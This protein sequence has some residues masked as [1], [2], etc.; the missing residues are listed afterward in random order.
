MKQN[1]CLKTFTL[2][3]AITLGATIASA[4]SADVA[5]PVPTETAT[6]GLLG[7]RYTEVAYNY[8]DLSGPEHADGFGLAFNQPLRANLDL[9]AGYNW[10]EADFGAVSARVHDAEIGVKAYT[11]LS[12]G[13]PYAAAAVGWTW[14]KAAG[15]SEDSF[16]Y[17]VG[18]GAE[19]QVAPAFTV[20]PFVNFVRATGFNASEVEIGARATYRLNSEWSLTARAQHEVVRHDDNSQEYSIGAIYRF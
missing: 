2:A 14:Q 10:A 19:F 1:T 8:I 6:A 20:T 5:V 17:K 9:T 15:Y 7:S 12:W 11:A 16:T 3:A 4:Q 13:K 18:V